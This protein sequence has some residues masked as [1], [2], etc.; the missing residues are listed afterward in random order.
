MAVLIFNTLRVNTFYKNLQMIS[1]EFY[2][3]NPNQ[4]Q[5]GRQAPQQ[6]S[7]MNNLISPEMFKMAQIFTQQALPEELK[8]LDPSKI[9][10]RINASQALIPPYFAVSKTSIIHRIKNLACPFIV[11]QWSRSVPDGQ[12]CIP[13]SNPN[14]PELYTPILFCLVFFLLSSLISGVQN[15]FSMDRLYSSMLKFSLV[16]TAEV[17]ISKMLF[18]NVGV[19]GNYPILSLIADFSCISFYISLVTLFSWNSWL[20]WIS[21]L[22]CALAALIWT[23]RT[24]N[25]EQCMAG[26]Q[27]SS[28]FITY[29]LLGF[30]VFQIIL[31]YIMAPTIYN[32]G[33]KTVVKQVQEVTTVE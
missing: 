13:L 15:S 5:G 22:Y 19:Q 18:K 10:Q 11:K 28:T 32:I 9:E 17:F 33:S 25:S 24:L 3:E 30:A 20:Y 8:N 27:T 4:F 21:F 23:L 26:R 6:P 7:P 16:I 1:G 29:I 14:A 12:Q 2:N 31:L